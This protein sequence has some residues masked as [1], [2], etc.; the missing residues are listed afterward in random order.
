M[1][2][3]DDLA[4][5]LS[6][7]ADGQTCPAQ[8][9]F[10]GAH[11]EQCRD[12]RAAIERH[13]ET[14]RLLRLSGDDHWVPPDLRL[15]VARAYSVRGS[16]PSRLP[17]LAA[18]TL[19]VT[20]LTGILQIAAPRVLVHDALPESTARSTIIAWMARPGCVAC[21]PI[22]PPRPTT[23]SV[24]GFAAATRIAAEASSSRAP[25]S[26]SA[27]SAPGIGPG[28]PTD[29][30]RPFTQARLVSSRLYGH[31]GQYLIARL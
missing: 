6:A 26:A 29:A 30:P 5:L 31:R 27:A 3:C 24:A 15:R 28:V 9:E 20:V 7:F 2:P 13:Y 14:G 18:L 4:D 21:Q 23:G 1:Q 12:C 8:T 25:A 22:Q 11:L 16:Q 19:S 17:F 10:I